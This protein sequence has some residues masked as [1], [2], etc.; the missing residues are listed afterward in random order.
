MFVLSLPMPPYFL[1]QQVARTA[2]A[3]HSV[4]ARTESVFQGTMCHLSRPWPRMLPRSASAEHAAWRAL[5]V[6][7]AAALAGLAAVIWWC[8]SSYIYKHKVKFS[9]TQLKFRTT[10]IKLSFIYPKASYTLLCVFTIS[11][12]QNINLKLYI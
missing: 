8:S 6:A 7:A 11:V 10:Q 2:W 3:S 5:M 4:S 9:N 12:S 1:D